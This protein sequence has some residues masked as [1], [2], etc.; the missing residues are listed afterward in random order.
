[1]VAGI[2]LGMKYL[3]SRTIIHRDLKPG[4]LLLDQE[5]RIRICDFGNSKIEACGTRMTTNIAFT[6]AYVAPE[7]LLGKDVTRLADVFAFGLILFEMVVG[8]RAFPKTVSVPQMLVT[9][10]QGIQLEIP[11]DVRPCVADLMRMCWSVDPA[12][13]PTF[14]DV[15]LYLKDIEFALFEDVDTAAV[16]AFISEVENSE[17]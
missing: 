1:M 4:N 11:S 15:F 9:Y 16:M 7:V 10:S 12:S 2:V 6:N 5:Y 14:R 8:K 3:H 17:Y 13:R